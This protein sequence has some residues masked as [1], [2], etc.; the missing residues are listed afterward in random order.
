[1]TMGG[2]EDRIPVGMGA[3]SLAV[4]ALVVAQAGAGGTFWTVE[5]PSTSAGEASPSAVDMYVIL[6]DGYPRAD[7]LSSIF[8]IDNSAFLAELESRG[9]GV[10]DDSRSNYSITWLT[11]ASV[12]Q[13][14]YVHEMSEIAEIPVRGPEQYRALGRL[15]NESPALAELRE[16]GYEIVSS[17]SPFSELELVTVDTAY[18][19][20]G[21]TWLE[22]EL[23]RES[24]LSRVFAGLVRD[25]VSADR[26]TGTDVALERLDEVAKRG[27]GRPVFMF[28]HVFSPHPPFV[29]EADGSARALPLC[30][31]DSCGLYEANPGRLELSR[32]QYGEALAG[33][34]SHLNERLL[35]TLD[36]LIEERPD[37]VI[38]LFSDHGTRYS[39]RGD[40]DEATRNFF[41]ARTPGIPGIFDE[42]IHTVNLM[43]TL[44]NAYLGT[45]IPLHEF[46]AWV[47]TGYPLQLDEQ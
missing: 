26:R 45:D 1:M 33:Q 16:A 13:M 9:F 15:V 36:V 3:L 27:D 44:L 29:F 40:P 41:A 32:E 22:S 23:I 46:R 7:T 4:L 6:L 37:A 14:D 25:W 47:S 30:Y 18:P 35:A 38:V 42:T 19:L 34:I 31:P 20:A 43:P 10:A 17:P 11:V 24:P 39:L 2:L 5:S 12:L 21:I 28:D 8:G